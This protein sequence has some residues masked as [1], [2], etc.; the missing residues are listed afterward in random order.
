[1]KI[2]SRRYYEGNIG[3]AANRESKKKFNLTDNSGL[4]ILEYGAYGWQTDRP[5]VGVENRGPM[6]LEDGD[7]VLVRSRHVAV[8]DPYLDNL[9]VQRTSLVGEAQIVFAQSY[10]Q[11]S[12]LQSDVHNKKSRINFFV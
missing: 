2:K 6:D 1:M 3:R 10:R 7:I 12:R 4:F 5:Y 8:M 11:L 9:E